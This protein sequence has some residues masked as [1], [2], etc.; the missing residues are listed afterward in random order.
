MRNSSMGR[1]ETIFLWHGEIT[2]SCRCAVKVQPCSGGGDDG[3]GERGRRGSISA[4]PVVKHQIPPDQGR[5][6]I[7]VLLSGREQATGPNPVLR[8]VSV[9]FRLSQ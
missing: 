7:L 2:R 3:T 9:T 5:S 8:R 1:D 6:P 4:K